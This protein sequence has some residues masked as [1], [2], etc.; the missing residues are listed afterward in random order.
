MSEVTAVVELW[1]TGRIK[2]FDPARR[3]G[4]IIPDDE[5]EDIFFRWLLAQE[6]GIKESLLRPGAQVLFK[7]HMPDGV[8]RRPQAIALKLIRK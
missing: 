6:Y 1:D 4:W 2:W 3:Y 5:G 8:G 7:W